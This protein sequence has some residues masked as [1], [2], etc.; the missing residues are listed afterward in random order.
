[1]A[2]AT[3]F[4]RLGGFVQ[5]NFIILQFFR[6]EVQRGPTG[7]K[8]RCQHG[9]MESSHLVTLTSSLSTIFHTKE[10]CYY[11]RLTRIT[12]NDLPISKPFG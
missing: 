8:L 11:T 3:D 1:M 5:Y 7:L 2:A 4:H 6:L 9:H 10:A 12:Q